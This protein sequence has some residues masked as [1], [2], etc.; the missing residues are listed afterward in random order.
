[1]CTLGLQPFTLIAILYMHPQT[2][3][4]YSSI[5]TVCAYSDYSHPFLYHDCMCTMIMANHSCIITVYAYP[6]Y[7]HPPLYQYLYQWLWPLYCLLR[8]NELQCVNSNNKNFPKTMSMFAASTA[9]VERPL[10]LPHIFFVGG[11]YLSR[12]TLPNAIF[13]PLLALTNHNFVKCRL[14]KAHDPLYFITD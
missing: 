9:H 4:I 6:D 13:L 8:D 1:M 11:H 3:T 14:I 10:W 2:I 12:I 7:S 5:I